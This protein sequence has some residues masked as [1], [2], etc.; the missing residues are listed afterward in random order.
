VAKV[1]VGR[2]NELDVLTAVVRSG[3]RTGAAAAFVAGDPG[4]GKSRLLAE[5][6]ARV[7]EQ[8]TFR[9]AGFEAERQVPLAAAGGLLRALSERGGEGDRLTALLYRPR[10]GRESALDPVRVLEAAN[11]ALSAV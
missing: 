8:P 6:C 10:N 7:E 11:R 4:S 3:A 9:L 1:F 2:E 5:V